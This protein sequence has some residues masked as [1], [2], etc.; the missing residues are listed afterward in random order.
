MQ[1]SELRIR[2]ELQSEQLRLAEVRE[3]VTQIHDP[4]LRE[5]DVED[6]RRLP[7]RQLG[8]MTAPA[9]ERLNRVLPSTE[10][11]QRHASDNDID[12][13]DQEYPS[14]RH[15]VDMPA[16]HKKRPSAHWHSL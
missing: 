2:A 9:Q 13:A 14:R 4:E 11:L 12:A 7:R 3:D 10:L 5:S 15:P 8:D 1:R 16:S 6:Q